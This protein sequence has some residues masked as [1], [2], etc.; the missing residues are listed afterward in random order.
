LTAG[1]AG[2]ASTAAQPSRATKDVASE[3]PQRAGQPNQN[4]VRGLPDERARPGSTGKRSS[5]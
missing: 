2:A 1:G 3:L 4:G 5:S